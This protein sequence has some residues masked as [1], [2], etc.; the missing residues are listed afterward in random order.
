MSFTHLHKIST[1]SPLLTNKDLGFRLLKKLSEIPKK[2]I[3]NFHFEEPLN[4]EEVVVYKTE[5]IENCK[6]LAHFIFPDGEEAY[7]VIKDDFLS[8]AWNCV[9]S[10]ADD[11]VN[12]S[13]FFDL[14]LFP[15]WNEIDYQF[16]K[17]IEKKNYIHCEKC[18]SFISKYIDLKYNDKKILMHGDLHS[19]NFVLYKDEFK[20]IDLENMHPA[21]PFSDFFLFSFLVPNAHLE[22]FKYINFFINA[23]GINS[24][25]IVNGMIHALKIATIMKNEANE[26]LANN[27]EKNIHLT[28]EEASKNID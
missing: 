3:F 27:I 22:L 10:S 12:L 6:T 2:G 28:I 18:S 17:L 26:F 8:K 16:E 23:K 15:A 7:P 1:Y 4:N 14:D 13:S 20:L 21:P 25:S 9:V 5:Q 19:G 11:L 24:V